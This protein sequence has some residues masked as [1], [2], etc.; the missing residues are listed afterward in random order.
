M[1]ETISVLGI[2]E[3]RPAWMVKTAGSAVEA[4]SIP[5]PKAFD[6]LASVV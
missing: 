4:S 6:F 3:N 2:N 1:L 5:G